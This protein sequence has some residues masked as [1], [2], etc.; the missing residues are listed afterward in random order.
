MM[1]RPEMYLHQRADVRLRVRARAMLRAAGK[2]VSCQVRNLSAGGVELYTPTAVPAIGER[3]E[4]KFFGNGV[5]LGP[6]PAETVR[7]SRYGVAF[8]FE[9]VDAALRRRILD[10]LAR[11]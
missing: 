8:K 10:A 4:L 3:V 9:G 6:L 11:M 7:R 2:V 1:T 5:E